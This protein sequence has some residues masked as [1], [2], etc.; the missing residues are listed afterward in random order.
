M[1]C[2]LEQ[3][4][5]DVHHAIADVL[6]QDFTDQLASLGDDYLHN[7]G[8]KVLYLNKKSQGYFEKIFDRIV[9]NNEIFFDDKDRPQFY[10]IK[11]K[12]P[13]IFS[14]PGSRFYFSSGLLHKYLK[15]E[16]LLIS[17][18]AVEI[19]KSKRVI[20]EKKMMIPLGFCNTEKMIQLTRVSSL[21]KYQLNEWGYLVLK[22]AGYD[23]SASLNWI[24]VQNRNIL[25]FAILL[26]DTSSI[27]REEHVFKSFMSKEGISI[28]ERKTTEANSSKEFYQLMNQIVSVE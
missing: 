18:L 17:A 26:G 28:N 20:Y 8:T 5:I 14:L 16:E 15:S 24:Q 10:I 23:A 2:S 1:S 22:R 19:V 11:D 21:F 9:Q 6:P 27:S 4:A 12:T 13:F 25:D 7:E 3:R